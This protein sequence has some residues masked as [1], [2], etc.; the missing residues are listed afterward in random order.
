MEKKRKLRESNPLYR[1]NKYQIINNMFLY[2]DAMEIESDKYELR[3]IDP[4]VAWS[5]QGNFY[6]LL[7]HLRVDP[8]LFLITL[9]LNGYTSPFDFDGET[10]SI[11]VAHHTN[12]RLG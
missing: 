2:Y 11:K 12:F 7:D 9:Y 4:G 3:M 8:Q 10:S 5:F 1:F 6:G